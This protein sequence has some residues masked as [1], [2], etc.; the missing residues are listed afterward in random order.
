MRDIYFSKGSQLRW[1]FWFCDTSNPIKIMSLHFINSSPTKIVLKIPSF[2]SST[3]ENFASSLYINHLIHFFL[4]FLQSTLSL[5]ILIQYFTNQ[6][7]KSVDSKSSQSNFLYNFCPINLSLG[8]IIFF[9]F[10]CPIL[11]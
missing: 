1:F 4:L 2:L 7:K 5:I 3:I 11:L 10:I 6:K 9:T 8:S